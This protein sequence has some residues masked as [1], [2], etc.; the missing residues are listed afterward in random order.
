MN[1][2]T[3]RLERDLGEIAAGAHPSPSAWESIVPRLGDDEASRF[4]F[5]LAPSPDRSK[6]R[7]DRGRRGSV[8]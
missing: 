8:W 1:Q 7:L 5:V 4:A 3:D 2:L 6:R